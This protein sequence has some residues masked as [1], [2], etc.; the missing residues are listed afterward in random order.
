[1]AAVFPFHSLLVAI[2][3]M[4]H[5]TFAYGRGEISFD[6]P[7]EA[8]LSVVRTQPFE[9]IAPSR[10]PEAVLQAVEHPIGLPALSSL[11]KPGQTVAF[12]CNDPTRVANSFA[13]MPVLV[14]L[15]NRAGIPDENMK[16]VF[17][18]GTHRPM[19]QAEVVEAVGEDVAR[20]L[21]HYNSISTVEGDFVDCGTTSRGTP[22]RIHKELCNVDHVILTG[23]IVHHYFSG[24]GG[25]R[26]AVLP[27][28]AA[29]ETVRIN[30]SFMLDDNAALGVTRGNPCY[31]DQVEG[32][33]LF[34]R[35]RSL[36][37]FNAVLDARHRFLKMF[38]GHFVQA[39]DVACRFVDEVYGAV[40]P[41]EADIVI[42]SCGGYPK[43]INVYQMQKTMVNA[44]CAVRK[45]GVVILLAEC[46]EGSGS[47]VLEDTFRRLKTPQAIRT[48]LEK[49]FRIGANKAF[50]I[51]RPMEKAAFILVTKLD[52]TLARDMLFAGAVETPEEALKLAESFVGEHPTIILMP[53]GSLTVPRLP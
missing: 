31:E 4:S 37:L 48:A 17:A 27:G 6:V 20:R 9:P 8:V 3:L 12:I 44:A 19:T 41:R 23:T 21:R 28:C 35:G 26:K 52:K 18:L 34:A 15:M 13:F 36:F 10:V 32:V 43:D 53:E 42:A 39:H 46:I 14:D 29:M 16:I 1:M 45:G 24:Y 51:T 25:G 33:S 47:S 2:P 38:A 11:V 22:V 50:A 40:I 5:H 49:D 7:D 30:H